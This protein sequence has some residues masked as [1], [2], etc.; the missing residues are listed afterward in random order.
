VQVGRRLNNVL[1]AEIGQA[2]LEKHEAL[3]QKN[4]RDKERA[5]AK[6][7]L[8]LSLLTIAYTTRRAG[9]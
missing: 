9:S 2:L 6:V 8:T 5:D 7:R 1:T 3:V 4:A